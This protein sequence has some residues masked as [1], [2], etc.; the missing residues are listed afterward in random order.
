MATKRKVPA[1]KNF[2]AGAIK[3]PGA[4]TK[5]I[6]GKPSKNPKKVAAQAKKPGKAGQRARFYQNVLKPAAA[7]RRK[8][9]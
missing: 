1:K 3:R 4:L 5:A 2:I 7:K 9:K 6:G 8:K